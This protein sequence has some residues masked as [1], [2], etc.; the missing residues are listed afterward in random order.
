MF[1]MVHYS[2][3]FISQLSDCKTELKETRLSGKI[4]RNND[5]TFFGFFYFLKGSSFV[6]FIAIRRQKQWFSTAAEHIP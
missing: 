2:V 3:E 4:A 5:K 1:I 6:D